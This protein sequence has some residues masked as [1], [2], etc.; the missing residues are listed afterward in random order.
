MT[1]VM[2][3][4]S[5]GLKITRDAIMARFGVSKA[6]ANRWLNAWRDARARVFP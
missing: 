1:F 3:A 6:T 5:R 4:E 2:W